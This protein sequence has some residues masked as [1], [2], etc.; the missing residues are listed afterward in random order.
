MKKEMIIKTILVGVVTIAIVI[1]VIYKNDNNKALKETK[2][3]TVVPTMYDEITTD[4]A[5]SPTFQLVWNDF[6]NELVKQ[7]IVFEEKSKMVDNLNKEYFTDKMISEDYYYKKYGLKTLELK[8][9]IEK[10][11]KE[12]FNQTSDIINDFDWD[13]KSLNN[14]DDS[15]SK[16]YFFYSMLYREFEYNYKFKELE[17]GSFKDVKDIKYFGTDEKS[18]DKVRSQIK[19]LFYNNEDDF[20]ISISTKDNDELIFY[21]NP[22]GTTFNEIYENLLKEKGKYKGSKSLL[23]EENFKAPYMDFK[24]KKEFTELEN[25]PFKAQDEDTCVIEKAMQSIE[26]QIHEKGGKVKSEAGLDVVKT[27]SGDI[28]EIRH[29]NID[30]TFALFLKE[31]K[32]DIP[33]FAMRVNDITKYQQNN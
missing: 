4:T 33:Y 19:V 30:D 29:F 2:G 1:G 16:R 31:N 8:D 17:K 27:A 14:D 20:A 32:K 23:D 25:K 10:G 22:K 15:D 24:V 12:K 5:W 6:K 7:D 9:E 11:I 3:I 18:K 28:T 26:F 21:K 13:E